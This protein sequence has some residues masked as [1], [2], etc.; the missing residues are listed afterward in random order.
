MPRSKLRALLLLPLALAL[1]ILQGLIDTIGVIIHYRTR[2]DWLMARFERAKR[3]SMGIAVAFMPAVVTRDPAVLQ[4]ILKDDF[5]N[6]EKGEEFRVRFEEMLGE[7][8]FNID[9]ASEC[10]NPRGVTMSS[11]RWPDA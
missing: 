4:F 1:R 3:D 6:F 7:G 10:G 5:D 9:G 8:I 2:L 11:A